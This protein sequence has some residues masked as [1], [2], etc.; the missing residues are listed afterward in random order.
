MALPTTSTKIP[1][2][3]TPP[4]QCIMEYLLLDQSDVEEL[5]SMNLRRTE[6][7][8]R[9]RTV[10][11]KQQQKPTKQS[12][13][14]LL[15]EL[16]S[17]QAKQIEEERRARHR[18]VQRRF[19]QRRKVELERTKEL[20][21][22]LEK[23]YSCLKIAAEE[24]DLK[25]ENR[26]LQARVDAAVPSVPRVPQVDHIQLLMQNQLELVKEF[27]EPLTPQ[28]LESTQ[29]KVQTEYEL[30]RRDGTYQT[31]GALVMGWSDFRKVEESSVKFVLS[32]KFPNVQALHLMNFTW[33]TLSLPATYATFFSPAFP[34]KIQVM[35]Q[36]GRNAVVIHRVLF[37]PHTQSSSNSLE[38]LWRVRLGDEYVIFDSALQHNAVQQCLGASY[39]WTQMT[40]SLGF[41]PLDVNKVNGCIFRHGGWLRASVTNADYWLMEMFFMALRYESAMVAPVFA[42]SYDE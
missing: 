14:N 38:L 28:E 39:K 42:L 25:A 5:E 20:A 1:P 18:A 32:K 37:N 33:D 36:F 27:Y 34:I 12:G 16:D 23:R 10:D 13:D 30:S 41:T 6:E 4:D 21:Q 35:Q 9:I 31:S 15:E 24:R 2:Y 40:T 26:E 11:T 19:I 22:T 8:N 17:G 3:W 7:L 29:L